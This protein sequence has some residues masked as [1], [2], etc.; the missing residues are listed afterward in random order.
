VLLLLVPEPPLPNRQPYS[1]ATF[2]EVARNPLLIVVSVI[3][4]TTQFVSFATSFGFVPV[5]AEGIGASDS[6]ISYLTTVMFAMSMAGTVATPFIVRAIGYRGTLIFAAVAV[7][8][9]SGV[10]PFLDDIYWLGASQAVNGLGRG[11]MNA[12]LI[13]LSVLAVAP[14]QRAT[15]MGVYQAI[16]AIG[17]LAGPVL[18]GTIADGVSL[19]AVFYVCA[20]V[21]MIGVVLTFVTRMPRVS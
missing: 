12:A 21:S 18:A 19:D 3:G 14:A 11:A 16:Y 7:A 8:I 2:L 9:G 20:A 10:V 17:M 15:A 4:I 1:K 13:T 5:Y 6:T